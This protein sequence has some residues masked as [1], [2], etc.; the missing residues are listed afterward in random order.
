MSQSLDLPLVDLDDEVEKAAGKTIREIFEHGGEEAFRD[1]ESD[2][3]KEV[4]R[5]PPT[6]VALGGGA[7]AGSK[8]ELAIGGAGAG[9]ASWRGG[10]STRALGSGPTGE[11]LAGGSPSLPNGDSALLTG[12]GVMGLNG[13]SMGA[14]AACSLA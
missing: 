3:L 7:A 1:F 11:K 5:Q 2:C 4:A 14:S 12:D 13:E 6:V 9:A 8:G 10:S